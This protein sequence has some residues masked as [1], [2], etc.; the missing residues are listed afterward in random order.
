M[1]FSA[2]Y[3]NP[4]APSTGA[5]V[6]N[7][8]DLT[9]LLS[10]LSPQ[11]TP[12]VSL[13]PKRKAK[14]T[15]HEWTIDSLASPD[16]SGVLESADV[17][18][19]DDKFENKLRIGNVIQGFRRSF[20]TTVVQDAVSSVK[21]NFAQAS[22]K[23][24]RELKRD[25][26]AAISSANDKTVGSGSAKAILR[27]MFKYVST[28]PG[29]DIP[30]LYTPAA[31]QVISSP[32]SN[33]LTEALLNSAL[34]SMYN[35]SGTLNNVTMIA[36]TGVRSDVADFVRT[37]G[38]TDSRQYNI[39]GTAKTVTLAVDVYNSDFGRINIV[40]SNPDCS[41]DSTNNDRALI[42]NLD[43]V[44]LANLIPLR[45][46]TLE[47]QGAGKRGFTET[48]ATLECLQPQAHASVDLG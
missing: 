42:V 5:G 27:G 18:S 1:A 20:G 43:Y 6:S 23:A 31:A 3:D 39:S 16:T 21:S 22:V 24:V 8:E 44:G 33:I 26:E 30:A 7:R 35:V 37:G 28:S 15:N 4:A 2:S 47:N 25:V 19:F 38:S 12:F 14:A 46:E 40:N 13:A 48:W 41:A 34:A 29:S 36:D 17:T 32:A 11:D 45:S 9:D 10:M